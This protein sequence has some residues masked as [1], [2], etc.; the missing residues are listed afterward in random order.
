MN[1][2]N[3][4]RSK[5]FLENVKSMEFLPTRKIFPVWHKAEVH[6]ERFVD[7][8]T[9]DWHIGYSRDFKQVICKLRYPEARCKLTGTFAPKHLWF[10]DHVRDAI[11]ANCLNL[12]ILYTPKFNFD[13]IGK[14]GKPALRYISDELKTYENLIVEGGGRTILNEIAFRLGV[15][16]S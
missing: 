16:D 15:R 7:D 11:E 12:E 6:I 10:P 14:Y 8:I 13:K 3:V 4:I 1:K 2:E 5:V 9:D